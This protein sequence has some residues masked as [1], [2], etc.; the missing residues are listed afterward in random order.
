MKKIEVLNVLFRL[1]DRDAASIS[2][3]LNGTPEA[4]GM[5]LLRLM[6]HGLVDR[7]LDD[8][9]FIYTLTKKGDAR[10]VYLNTR[11]PALTG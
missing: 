2:R 3:R 10:R 8:G 6:R 5:M 7:D 11:E 1:R 4:A 9:L